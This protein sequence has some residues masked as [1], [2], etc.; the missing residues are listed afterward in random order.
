MR[1]ISAEE[2]QK[3]RQIFFKVVERD[4][5]KLE[6]KAKEYFDKEYTKIMEEINS[7]VNKKANRGYDWLQFNMPT[8]EYKKVL[9][10]FG[11]VDKFDDPAGPRILVETPL[12][13]FV[14]KIG[15]ELKIAGYTI[16]I[17]W[18]CSFIKIFWEESNTEEVTNKTTCLLS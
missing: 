9:I 1:L 7:E 4:L 10:G 5:Q 11:F 2:A 16:K 18:R 15:E 13:K 6:E 17:G 14:E 8:D 12:T 3:K